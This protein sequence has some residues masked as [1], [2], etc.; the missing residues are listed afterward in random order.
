MPKPYDDE[1]EDEF[2]T[3]AVKSFMSEGY[4]Q[5]Q[6]VGR[7]YGF[8]KTHKKKKLRN[9]LTPIDTSAQRG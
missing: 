7:A 3:R 8:W 9:N 4:S 1:D 5:K 6:A 2:V